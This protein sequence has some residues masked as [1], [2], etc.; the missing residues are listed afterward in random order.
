MPEDSHDDESKDFTPTRRDT[1]KITALA[2]AISGSA[3]TPVTA[4]TGDRY[5]V[6]NDAL[7]IHHKLNQYRADGKIPDASGNGVVGRPADEYIDEGK[8]T[9]VEDEQRGTVLEFNGRR[10][11]SP[12]GS[13]NIHAEDLPGSLESGEPLTISLW[14]KPNGVIKSQQLLD[15][16]FGC[17]IG[18]GGEKVEARL[19]NNGTGVYA[20]ANAYI[21]VGEWNHLLVTV[22]QEK[23]ELLINNEFLAQKYTNK[24]RDQTDPV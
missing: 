6:L 2:T 9:F 5:D 12:S 19:N 20:S 16:S 21:T 18:I 7:T 22:S 11:D 3:T 14:V 8:L 10:A 24:F 23:I 1:L 4:Q 15:D 17:E 13:Y